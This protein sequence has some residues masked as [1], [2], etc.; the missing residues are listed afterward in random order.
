[1]YWPYHEQRT[2]KYI[3]AVHGMQANNEKICR[4]VEEETTAAQQNNSYLT[5]LYEER[6]KKKGHLLNFHISISL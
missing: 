2:P 1:M 3:Y 6:E 4:Y 5:P